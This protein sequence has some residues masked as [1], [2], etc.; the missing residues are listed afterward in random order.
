MLEEGELKLADETHAPSPT[1][2]PP[3][4]PAAVAAAPDAHVEPGGTG[5]FSET[6]EYRE[7]IHTKCAKATA[8]KGE[9]LR[10]VAIPPFH[11]KMAG[12]LCPHC[13][14]GDAFLRF[15]WKDTGENLSAYRW[16]LFFRNPI[17]GGTSWLVR[18][19]LITLI[20]LGSTTL[21]IVLAAHSVASERAAAWKIGLA[22]GLC[23]AVLLIWGIHRISPPDYRRYR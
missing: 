23:V 12:V 3:A 16:R 13:K 18:L 15:R 5:L 22:L 6:P 2:A 14:L 8:V 9:L 11:S 19:L 20:P 7:C 1:A 21:G 10:L 17:G 4:A